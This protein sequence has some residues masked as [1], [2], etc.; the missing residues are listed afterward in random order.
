RR[1]M[2]TAPSRY[3]ALNVDVA[4]ATFWL[5]GDAHAAAEILGQDGRH[6]PP[7]SVL[8]PEAGSPPG[9]PPVQLSVHVHPR[10]AFLYYYAGREEDAAEVFLGGLSDPDLDAGRHGYVNDGW[11]GMLRC[12]AA[13]R[14]ERPGAEPSHRIPTADVLAALGEPEAMYERLERQQAIFECFLETDAE[15]AH[16]CGP[17]APGT[18]EIPIWTVQPYSAYL[19]EPRFQRLLNAYGVIGHRNYAA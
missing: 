10:N 6:H 12:V 16:E 5:T 18:F 4:E 15:H 2:A 11:E 7:G 19:S 3:Y 13:S 8:P 14:R 17:G 9:S 1:V